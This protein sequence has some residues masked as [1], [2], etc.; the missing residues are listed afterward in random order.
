MSEPTQRTCGRRGSTGRRRLVAAVIGG[1]AMC[2]RDVWL[3]AG[4]GGVTPWPLLA[5]ETA[6]WGAAAVG[7]ATALDCPVNRTTRV[8]G[9]RVGFLAAAAL[10][11]AFATHGIRL[12]IYFR[13][14]MLSPM[15]GPAPTGSSEG[16]G[17]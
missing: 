14:R 13:R 11:V 2:A 9:D 17:L 10:S 8:G 7:A 5:L 4:G 15:S 6:A 1:T 12:A 16:G 3:V